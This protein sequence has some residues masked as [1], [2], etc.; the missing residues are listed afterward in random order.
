[1][2]KEPDK[3]YPRAYTE[4]KDVKLI[5][6]DVNSLDSKIITDSDISFILNYS[7]YNYPGFTAKID[8]SKT[9]IVSGKPFGQIT[10]LVPAGKHEV[11]VGY[12]ESRF[13]LIFDIISIGAIVIS[14]Y[15]V[16]KKK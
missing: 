15:L 5:I 6:E 7:K 3:N 16:L 1:M 14:T 2:K 4:N 8:A 9:K 11:I 10:I 13:R 12:N